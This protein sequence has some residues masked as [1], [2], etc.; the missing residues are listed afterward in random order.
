MQTIISFLRD[1]DANNDRTW[2][3][4]NKSR[5]QAAQ[6]R[7]NDIVDELILA[8]SQFDPT[9]SN[10]T[11]KDC[12][13]RIYRD[14]RFS[15][16][17][18]PYKT[19]MGAYI[20]PGG[21]KSGYSGYYFH[22]GTG[23]GSGY[24]HAHMLASG[25]YMCEP[26]VLKPLREDIC[27]GEGD[28]HDIVTRQVAPEFKLDVENSLQRVPAGFPSDSPYSQYLRLR[29]YCLFCEPDNRF[30]LSPDVV[31]RTA[32]LFHT[33]L[34]FLQYINRAITYCKEEKMMNGK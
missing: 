28:F 6:S 34:P 4:Q 12:I 8:I 27:Y 19:H 25:D 21:K 9:V 29:N 7:F 5:Y 15:K 20:C 10:L 32:E 31:A 26:D 18:S 30:M 1:I 11:A 16:D 2:F 17:K 33:T 22:V 23:L 14:T 3:N 24:P 13:Y